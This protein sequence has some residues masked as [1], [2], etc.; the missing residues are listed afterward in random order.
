LLVV[1]GIL[2]I[3]GFVLL[4]LICL[5]AC[6]FLLAFFSKVRYYVKVDKVGG[7]SDWL[8]AVKISWLLGMIRFAV[9][10]GE[11]PNVRILGIKA[12]LESLEKTGDSERTEDSEKAEGSGKTEDSGKP[13]RPKNPK[14]GTED[15]DKGLRTATRNDT[16]V[17]NKTKDKKKDKTKFSFE[18]VRSH[19]KGLD[20]DKIMSVLSIAKELI[21]K[22]APKKFRVRGKVGFEE[23]HFTG[24]VMALTSAAS[25][26]FDIVLE[27]DFEEPNLELD[28]DILGGFRLYS[29]IKPALKLYKIYKL[30]KLMER[31]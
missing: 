5:F 21:L 12:D 24:L 13:K 26:K 25:A 20:K 31:E 18:E 2:N 15:K 23:P 4:G 10:N 6:L 7:R 22:I 1:L 29:M 16:A 11:E 19:F 17:K 3:T 9:K 30:Y 8:Y 14:D 28:A 27:G